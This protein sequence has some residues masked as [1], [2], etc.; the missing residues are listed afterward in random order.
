MIEYLKEEN[1]L[2]RD[3]IDQIIL[4]K[5]SVQNIDIS[6]EAKDIFKTVWEISQKK[7]LEMSADRAPYI[8]QSQSLNIFIE[9]ADPKII[10]SV[11]MYGHSLGLKTGS[12]YIR[13]K[14]ILSSQNFSMDYNKEKNYKKERDL[15]DQRDQEYEPCLTC[16]S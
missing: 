14:P 4:N 9:K 13:T 8:C 15:K 6:D 11:H 2:S 1:L 10:N 7:L 12:Y 3:I 5:G 16:S